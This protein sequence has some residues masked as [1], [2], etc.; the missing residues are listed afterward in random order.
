MT[1]PRGLSSSDM[2]HIFGGAP[3]EYH[4]AY[5]D[6]PEIYGYAPPSDLAVA[7]EREG[8]MPTDAE[9]KSAVAAATAVADDYHGKTVRVIGALLGID[10]ALN[11]DP[12]R[13]LAAVKATRDRAI[14]AGVKAGIEAARYEVLDA[15]DAH[16]RRAIAA[17]DPAAIAAKVTL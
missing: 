16:A 13:Y 15:L 1:L 9:M 11:M 5:W 4:A 3:R 8:R 10:P 14:L 2:R 17:L 6:G 12:G 7:I